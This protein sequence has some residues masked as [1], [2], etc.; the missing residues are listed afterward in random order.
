MFL[1]G[2]D[3]VKRGASPAMSVTSSS[4]IKMRE[5]P[6]SFSLKQ[7]QNDLTSTKSKENNFEK[8]KNGNNIISGTKSCGPSSISSETFS[9]IKN[10]PLS[11]DAAQS[12]PTKT[13]TS[14]TASPSSQTMSKYLLREQLISSITSPPTSASS[15]PLRD[16]TTKVLTQHSGG[17]NNNHT[18]NSYNNNHD[19]GIGNKQSQSSL[20]SEPTSHTVSHTSYRSQISSG[21]SLG[22]YHFPSTNIKTNIEEISSLSIPSSSSSY[23][24]SSP[25]R[26]LSNIIPTSVARNLLY[27]SESSYSDKNQQQQNQTNNFASP[28]HIIGAMTSASSANSSQGST[29]M[30]IYGTLPKMTASSYMSS[31]ISP[32]TS[33]A[34]SGLAQTSSV[35]DTIQNSSSSGFG[36]IASTSNNFNFYSN[37]RQQFSSLINSN[38]GSNYHTLGSYRVQYSSTNPF[39]P[40]FDPPQGDA[41]SPITSFNLDSKDN[42]KF[43]DD[44]K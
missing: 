8:Y 20:M 22:T 31:S 23:K 40:T 28:T 14:L 18:N 44:L 17:N 3:T 7:D 35:M 4:T 34:T 19:K 36:S 30:N 13:A 10:I 21:P 5:S 25:S 27:Q 16:Y 2:T 39:L 26:Q 37:D 6:N 15:P 32:G 24:V 41:T 43:E 38:S 11:S 33:A 9:S 42:D 29:T 12:S 1:T